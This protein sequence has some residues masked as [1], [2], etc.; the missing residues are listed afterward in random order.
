MAATL[1]RIQARKAQVFQQMEEEKQGGAKERQRSTTPLTGTLSRQETP[2]SPPT[3]SPQERGIGLKTEIHPLLLETMGKTALNSVKIQRSGGT[4]GDIKDNPYL[5]HL[6][7]DLDEL[8][9]ED[10]AAAK[11]VP[12]KTKQTT[13]D[14]KSSYTDSS[15]AAPVGPTRRPAIQLGHFVEPGTY[16]RQAEAMRHAFLEKLRAE[17]EAEEAARRL[18]EQQENAERK[19]DASLSRPVDGIAREREM[20]PP[21]PP[22]IEWWDQQLYT[23]NEDQVHFMDTIGET[24]KTSTEQSFPETITHYIHH[25]VPIVQDGTQVPQPALRLHLTKRETKRLRKNARAERLKE[26]QDMIR[27]GLAPA[28]PPKVKL[29]NLMS[30]LTNEAIANPT[31][32]EARVRAEVAARRRTHEANNAERKLTREQRAEKLVAKEERHRTEHGTYMAAFRTRCPLT[33]PRQRFKVAKNAQQ[34][35]LGGI[36]VSVR[37]RKPD[38]NAANALPLSPTGGFSVII[39]QGSQTAINKY[40]RLLLNRINW[41]ESAPPRE[42]P[43]ED[44]VEMEDDGDDDEIQQDQVTGDAQPLSKRARK[45]LK[46]QQKKEQ[47]LVSVNLDLNACEE[48]WTG[49]VLPINATIPAPHSKKSNVVTA[50]STKTMAASPRLLKWCGINDMETELDAKDL[51]AKHNCD[52]FWVLAHSLQ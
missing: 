3:D 18:K 50:D 10:E 43:E 41:T 39:V 31:L 11:G 21:T 25:P 40:S 27:L 35:H 1:A 28:P 49:P 45:K 16:I 24:P 37:V 17:R 22:E 38:P 33:D 20:K 19:L 52:S 14:E 44:D 48:I 51:L 47:E 4:T 5:S 8:D 12:S 26:Q 13:I 30:V 36:A 42:E 15:L 32:V 6:L 9:R 23:S 7:D 29:T 2:S 46:E 34:L